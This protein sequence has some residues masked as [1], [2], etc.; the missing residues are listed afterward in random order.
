MCAPASNLDL[1]P[2]HNSGAPLAVAG[3]VR[4]YVEAV[5]KVPKQILGRDVE[6]SDHRMRCNQRSHPREESRDCVTL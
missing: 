6:K 3:G 1:Q 2:T 5:E 4:P